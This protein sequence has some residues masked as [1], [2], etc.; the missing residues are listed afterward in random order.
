M[1]S[2]STPWRFWAVLESVI[3]YQQSVERGLWRPEAPQICD[4]LGV[5]IDYAARR[6]MTGEEVADLR[7]KYA[8]KRWTNRI[9]GPLR[10][11]I[12]RLKYRRAGLK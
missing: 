10:Y 1:R 4:P 11:L 5:E 9:P 3:D 12:R 6:A 8:R 2:A 7:R